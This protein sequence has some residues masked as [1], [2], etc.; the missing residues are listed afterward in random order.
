MRYNN[1]DITWLGHDCFVVQGSRK[2]IFDPYQITQD[3]GFA[4]FVFIT[5]EHFDHCSVEDIKK[6]IS[7]NTIIITIPDCVSK[8]SRLKVKNIVPVNPGQKKDVEGIGVET[9]PAYN[10]NKFRSPGLLFHPPEDQ[11]VGFIVTMDSKR[12]YHAGDTDLIPEMSALF[13]IDIAFVPVSGTY[14]MT[15][16]E[17]ASAVNSFRPRL[18][19]PMHYGSIVGSDKDA[20]EF[21][22]LSQVSVD[23]LEK[24]K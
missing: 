17:A 20:L 1:I 24:A 19:I 16:K 4:D 13:N 7:P 5:H 9:V 23:I 14:V 8:V 15:A 18:A 12:F 21:K 10:I 2:L 6:V 3:V 11:R 22:E